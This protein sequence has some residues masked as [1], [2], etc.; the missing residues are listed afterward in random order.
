MG[1]GPPGPA[2]ALTASPEPAPR[3]PS[4]P[5][6]L[7][8]P[9]PPLLLLGPGHLRH[10]SVTGLLGAQARVAVGLLHHGR[11]GARHVRQVARAGLA[12]CGAAAVRRMQ[13]ACGLGCGGGSGVRLSDRGARE[14]SAGCCCY[15]LACD[16]DGPLLSFSIFS[17]SATGWLPWAVPAQE[18]RMMA[19]RCVAARAGCRPEKREVR[20]RSTGCGHRS[21]TFAHAGCGQA[22]FVWLRGQPLGRPG[23]PCHWAGRAAGARTGEEARRGEG[24]GQ[25]RALQARGQD[26]RDTPPGW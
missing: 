17:R 10:G 5:P 3:A 12:V 14:G 7:L 11:H 24:G 2:R 21:S 26:S 22:T 16:I 9:P 20:T 25:G 23:I 18:G 8:L 4:P 6:P 19:P 1:G 13:G 15:G